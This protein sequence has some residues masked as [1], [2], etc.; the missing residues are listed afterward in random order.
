MSGMLEKGAIGYFKRE[1]NRRTILNALK[2]LSDRYSE[3]EVL[4]K[5]KTGKCR[6]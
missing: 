5:D 1:N 6:S 2:S 3:T 4:V